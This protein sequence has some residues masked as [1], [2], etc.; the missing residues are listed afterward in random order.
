LEI[1]IRAFD[2]CY[3]QLPVFH[4]GNTGSN[5]V[6]DA[7]FFQQVT[8]SPCPF[9]RHKKG[10]IRVA[11]AKSLRSRAGVFAGIMPLEVGTN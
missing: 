1:A 3:L 7:K 10:T 8:V 4:G 6:G 2:F 11:N 9:F 5:P